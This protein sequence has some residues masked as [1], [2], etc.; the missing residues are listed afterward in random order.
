MA[1]QERGPRGEGRRLRRTGPRPAP[2]RRKA[3]GDGDAA[4]ETAGRRTQRGSPQ[5]SKLQ[6]QIPRRE[7]GF[8][9]HWVSL[10]T[11]GA[12]GRGK[13]GDAEAGGHGKPGDAGIR[14][15]RKVLQSLEW[16]QD[17][18]PERL[19]GHPWKRTG[20]IWA[21]A[22]SAL[23]L[24]GS[25]SH[26]SLALEAAGRALPNRGGGSPRVTRVPQAQGPQGGARLSVEEET[27]SS[28]HLSI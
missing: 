1:L 20:C 8:Q 13:P 14:G 5:A 2:G 22:D 18:G 15:H 4:L 11:A 10:A 19:I 17:T 23:H 6:R 27:G 16:G 24:P 25:L 28:R 9:C 3:H 12:R 26:A 21:H 7:R